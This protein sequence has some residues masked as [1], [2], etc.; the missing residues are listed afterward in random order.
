MTAVCG[1]DRCF[2]T[3]ERNDRSDLGSFINRGNGTQE[4]KRWVQCVTPVQIST[5]TLWRNWSQHFYDLSS[6]TWWCLSA[7]IIAPF[8]LLRLQ[9]HL[10]TLFKKYKNTATVASLPHSWPF[11]QGD[12]IIRTILWLLRYFQA[13]VSAFHPWDIWSE[14]GTV[15][16]HTP[17]SRNI[18]HCVS[19]VA[20]S[21]LKNEQ[22]SI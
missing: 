17:A 16:P 12:R 8:H 13:W 1:W 15:T 4:V 10:S 18:T 19:I 6:S 7:D 21:S 22:V 14:M 3:Q 2:S 20:N 11:R 5:Q 9:M